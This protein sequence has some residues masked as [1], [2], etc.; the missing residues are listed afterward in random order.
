MALPVKPIEKST[1]RTSG[2]V[3]LMV[4]AARDL[5]RSS[6]V[7]SMQVERRAGR[8]PRATP[9]NKQ[10]SVYKKAVKAT[11]MRRGVR[12]AQA[13]VKVLLDLGIKER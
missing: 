11:T 2:G 9:A 8:R 1:Y 5:Y 12:D 7:R 6:H 3:D 10:A 13:G 4:E